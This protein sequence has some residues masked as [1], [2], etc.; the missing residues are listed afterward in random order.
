MACS[1]ISWICVEMGCDL[2]VSSIFPSSRTLSAGL[3]FCARLRL[4]SNGSLGPHFPIFPAITSDPRY[5]APLRLPF[6]PLGF[7]C[8][9]SSTDTWLRPLALCVLSSSSFRVGR[10]PSTPGLFGRPG[11]PYLPVLLSR[12]QMA[13]PSSQATLLNSCPALRPRWCPQHSP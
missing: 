5:Y 10:L 1:A 6:T 8:F 13:L 3:S 12:K 4:P 11:P 7:L 9:R 2:G